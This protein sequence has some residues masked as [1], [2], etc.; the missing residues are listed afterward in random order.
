MA[1][2]C[3]TDDNKTLRNRE[4]MF[5]KLRVV[6]ENAAASFVKNEK[7]RTGIVTKVGNKKYYFIGTENSLIK[8]LYIIFDVRTASRVLKTFVLTTATAVKI[9]RTYINDFTV[10]GAGESSTVAI[11]SSTEIQNQTHGASLLLMKGTAPLV[12]GCHYT[13]L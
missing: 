1:L 4:E 8:Y 9:Q 5:E 2:V 13:L 10:D 7:I 6:A 12:R 11:C 3:V